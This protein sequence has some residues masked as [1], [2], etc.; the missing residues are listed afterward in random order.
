MHRYETTTW[1]D[2]KFCPYTQSGKPP[3]FAVTGASN[4]VICRC[5][6]SEDD[7]IEVLRWFQDEDHQEIGVDVGFGLNSLAWSRVKNGDPLVCVAG[8]DPRIKI[9]N[10]VT[11]EIVMT[12]AGHGGAIQDLAVCP[13]DP[14]VL[15]SASDD[16]GIRIWSLDPAH[17]KQRCA[18]ILHGEGHQESV[19]ALGFHRNGKWLLSGGLDARVNLWHIPAVQKGGSL[20]D[21][22]PV[23]HYPHFSSTEIHTDYID[24]IQFYGDLILS[25]A[26]RGGQ[27]ILWRIDN[28][29]GAD[30][31]A[32][33]AAPVPLEATSFENEEVRLPTDW[34]LK[35]RSAWDGRFQRLLAFGLPNVGD[36]YY[37]RFSLFHGLGQPPILAAGNVG[38]STVFFWDL[39]ALEDAGVGDALSLA[40]SDPSK[41]L[42]KTWALRNQDRAASEASSSSSVTA[43]VA[44]SEVE[45]GRSTPVTGISG[46]RPV[47]R[48]PG[49]RKKKV[50]KAKEVTVQKGIGDPFHPIKAHKSVVVPKYAF[51]VRQVAWSPCGDWCIATGDKGVIAIFRR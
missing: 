9:L 41:V 5:I 21:R 20:S 48:P 3:V 29:D 2:I 23:I 50:K 16:Q 39:Q 35:T 38:K 46:P 34:T 12:L 19:L 43:S 1:Y 31:S 22:T 45:S 44:A 6:P 51:T 36:E 15:A 18:A 8:S 42:D 13:T 33:P 32:P 14:Y 28:F 24:C 17:E 11:G 10:V 49:R 27:I 26:A 37:L 30:L 47:G 7:A 40:D 25:R 4:T